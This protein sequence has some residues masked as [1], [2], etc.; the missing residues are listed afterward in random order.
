MNISTKKIRKLKRNETITKTYFQPEPEIVYVPDVTYTPSPPTYQPSAM[1][2]SSTSEIISV[3]NDF[4]T[5]YAHLMKELQY[6]AK[7]KYSC[8][9]EVQRY[10]NCVCIHGSKKTSARNEIEPIIENAKKL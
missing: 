3:K 8:D 10:N 1:P 7:N 4:I 2:S 6:L 5:K 9:L